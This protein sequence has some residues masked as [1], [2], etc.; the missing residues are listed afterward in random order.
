MAHFRNTTHAN[1]FFFFFFLK[2]KNNNIFLLEVELVSWS[3]SKFYDRWYCIRILKIMGKQISYSNL[4]MTAESLII[5]TTA[6][7][8][9]HE[10]LMVT[11]TWHTSKFQTSPT[12]STSSTKYTSHIYISISGSLS[13]K[14]VQHIRHRQNQFFLFKA[15]H[16]IVLWSQNWLNI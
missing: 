15:I 16:S 5:I 9:R 3:Q 10:S 7:Q 11:L 13:N 4:L 6:Q 8:Q 2:S 12:K 14:C 1:F